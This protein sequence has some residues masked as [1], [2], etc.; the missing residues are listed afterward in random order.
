MSKNKTI[1]FIGALMTFAFIAYFVATNE[2]L[3]FDSIIRET[4]YGWRNTWFT[5]C[6]IFITYLAN[7]QT[8]I[9]F[10]F[11]TLLFPPNRKHFGIPMATSAILSS[12]IYKWMKTYFVRPRPDI[13][14]HLIVQGGYSFPSGH[15]MTGLVFYGMVIWLCRK[16]LKNRIAINGITALL[17]LLIFFIGFSRIYLGVHYPTDVLAGWA[18]GT[19]LLLLL[20][21]I[22]QYYWP[23]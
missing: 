21:S 5:T 16:N 4:I 3:A 13:S 17:S 2:V 18:L 19:C 11:A 22:Y 20:V 12:I 6:L 14:L 8:V 10:C 7:W 9:L 23:E 15:S 1:I